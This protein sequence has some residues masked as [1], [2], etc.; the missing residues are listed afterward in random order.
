MVHKVA[1]AMERTWVDVISTLA[2]CIAIGDG[3]CIA[4]VVV[5]GQGTILAANDHAV[6]LVGMPESWLVNRA[7]ASLLVRGSEAMS[8]FLSHNEYLDK[9]A[10]LHLV[11]RTVDG[12]ERLV[13]AAPRV[14]RFTHDGGRLI[15]LPLIET[16]AEDQSGQIHARAVHGVESSPL[17]DRLLATHD[18]EMKRVSSQLYNGIGQALATIK[19]MVEDASRH[20]QRG[21]Y[22]AGDDILDET[23]RCVR[24][25]ISD[26]R[27][28]S[29][30]MHPSTLDDLGLLPTLIEHCRRFR[31]G[32]PNI[33]LT[34]D[35]NV[36]ESRISNR[37]KS[38]IFRIVQDAM[39]AIA[40]DSR[41]THASI[42]LRVDG[43]CLALTIVDN[44]TRSQLAACRDAA[45]KPGFADMRD[46]VQ[47]SGGHVVIKTTGADTLV[48]ACWCLQDEL[49]ELNEAPCI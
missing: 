49:Q 30:E 48:E 11:L 31:V 9:P 24:E 34:T 10:F 13:S 41:A 39:N 35:F 2:H 37:M 15:L 43:G 12:S 47:A 46:R 44:G 3:I 36:N 32:C 26:I 19:F 42:A 20:L 22:A 28:M 4:S 7:M 38:A 17:M 18:A 33:A 5:D 27:R 21:Q 6:A 8:A 25:A 40:S 45:A 16:S 23:V 29:Q 1:T 14:F